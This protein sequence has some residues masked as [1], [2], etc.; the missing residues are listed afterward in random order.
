MTGCLN[1]GGQIR[2]E[3]TNSLSKDLFIKVDQLYNSVEKKYVHQSELVDKVFPQCDTSG[4][5]ASED[6][7]AKYF[8]TSYHAVE[9][10]N[11]ALTIKW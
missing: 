8:Y 2:D 3:T 6:P 9:S 11:N 7:R 5:E 1:G 4:S 10:T